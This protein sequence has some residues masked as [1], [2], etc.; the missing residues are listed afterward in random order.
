[1]AEGCSF[2]GQLNKFSGERLEDSVM[3]TVIVINDLPLM[4]NHKF[5]Q[6]VSRVGKKAVGSAV[7]SYTRK[8]ARIYTVKSQ[9]INRHIT[10]L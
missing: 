5:I 7:L 1:V 9:Q 6:D 8:T 2:A 10:E 3:C 4:Q